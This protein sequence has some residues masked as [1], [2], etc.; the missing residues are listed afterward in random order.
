MIEEIKIPAAFE[1]SQPIESEQ[2]VAVEQVK[3]SSDWNPITKIVFRFAFAYLVLYNFP[4]PLELIPYVSKITEPYTTLW[5]KVVPWVG[6]HFFNVN[7]TV[8]TNGSG[9][10]TYDYLLCFCFA[11]AAVGATMIWSILDRKRSNYAR[12]H[13]WLNIY[14][15]YSLALTMVSYGAAKVI[16][17]Q[18]P[19]PSLDRLLQPFGDASP[20]GLLWT[21]MGASMAFNIFT[22][23]G[24]FVGGLLLSFRRTA[25]LGALVVIAVMSNVVML[26]FSYDVPVK[27]Y[28]LHLL[29]MAVFL[30]IPH[31]RQLINLLLLNR[32]TEPVEYRPYF[33]RP[34]LN[35]G[36]QILCALLVAL[37]VW[38]AL[39][40]SYTGRHT[41]GDL[42]PRSPLY[43][44]WNVEEFEIDGEVKPPL[45]TD[46]NRWR[47]VVFDNPRTFS[48]QLMSDSRSRFGLA[49]D[50]EKKTLALTK[51][52][53]PNW[54]T[55]LTY[56]RIDPEKLTLDGTFDGK[57]IR[58]KLQRVE[59]SQFLLVN[60]GFHWINEFPFNR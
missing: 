12:L 6:S 51:R 13:Q 40:R 41:Y 4:F 49:L 30:T 21:F 45:I 38:Q 59:P 32:R 29:G 3:T 20:M 47:R 48:L 17:T 2:A 1:K 19:N 11:V 39:N 15:R 8:F 53:D 18:F 55:M 42:S 5:H 26:N 22:G 50:A 54:K 46:K 28:S 27:L 56:E 37:F 44:I 7:I 23:G 36:A 14:V 33:A 24:E 34:W 35:R 10:T 16:K 60:R 43:G 52:D 57:K 25:L 9:D 58:A 31:M